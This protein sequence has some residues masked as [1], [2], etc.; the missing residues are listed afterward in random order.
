MARIGG[1]KAGGEGFG[2]VIDEEGLDRREREEEPLMKG[3]ERER[4][5]QAERLQN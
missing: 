5:F 4:D 2:E 3:V 1:K